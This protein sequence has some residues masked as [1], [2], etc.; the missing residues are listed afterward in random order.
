MAILTFYLKKDTQALQNIPS[1]TEI[2]QHICH[3]RCHGKVRAYFGHKEKT[4][5]YSQGPVEDSSFEL[6]AVVKASC[7]DCADAS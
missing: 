6:C 1:K 7:L 5:I 3:I 2:R 4:E